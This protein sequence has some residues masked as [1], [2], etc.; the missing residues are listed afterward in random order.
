MAAMGTEEKS[1]GRLKSQMSWWG[2]SGESWQNQAPAVAFHKTGHVNTSPGSCKL[3]LPV[4]K[5]QSPMDSREYQIPAGLTCL[6]WTWFPVQG[7][8]HDTPC[9]TGGVG[10]SLGRRERQRPKPAWRELE[11]VTLCMYAKEALHVHAVSS[12]PAC[13]GTRSH[14]SQL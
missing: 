11:L 7:A 2:M 5:M 10:A 9:S 14:H 3:T 4:L 1:R 13:S 8:C 6:E 12:F